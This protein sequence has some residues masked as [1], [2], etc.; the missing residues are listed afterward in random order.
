MGKQKLAITYVY[1]IGSDRR[2]IIDG[3]RDCSHHEPGSHV[4]WSRAFV[5][6]PREATNGAEE[7]MSSD[8]EVGHVGASGRGYARD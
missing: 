3:S 1:L 6:K 2:C 8:E 5:S 4:V 7:Q